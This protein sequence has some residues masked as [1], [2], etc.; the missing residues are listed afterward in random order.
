[1]ADL[2]KAMAE[3]TEDAEAHP[4]PQPGEVGGGHRR[5]Y[6]VMPGGQ[7]NSADYLARWI[8]RD[9]PDASPNGLR[10]HDLD[11]ACTPLTCSETSSVFI[12]RPTAQRYG[13]LAKISGLFV[14]FGEHQVMAQLIATRVL[15]SP[16]IHKDFQFATFSS[17]VAILLP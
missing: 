9:R 16:L 2:G 14:I 15:I 13:V 6:K 17:L 5:N 10:C 8:A 11:G 12:I 7:G 1:M 3:Q 4:L